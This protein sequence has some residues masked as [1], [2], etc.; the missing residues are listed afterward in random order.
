MAKLIEYANG[1]AAL[2]PDRLPAAAD[3]YWAGIRA[4]V[5]SD[6]FWVGDADLP[7]S[8]K[9]AYGTAVT[10]LLATDQLV[11]DQTTD[12]DKALAMLV[13]L[14]DNLVALDAARIALK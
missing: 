14:R 3:P 2:P 4:I 11:Q 7:T 9:E 1:I 6:F 13:G 12:S 10:G 8:A 5:T